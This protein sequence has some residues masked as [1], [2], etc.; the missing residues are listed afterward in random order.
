MH[1]GFDPIVIKSIAVDLK[2]PIFLHYST[3]KLLISNSEKENVGMIYRLPKIGILGIQSK[4]DTNIYTLKPLAIW[5]N[6][7]YEGYSDFIDRA[8]DFLSHGKK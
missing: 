2:Y 5:H 1:M 3:K 7:S 6:I 8:S 4:A